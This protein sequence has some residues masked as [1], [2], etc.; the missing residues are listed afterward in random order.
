MERWRL[1]VSNA[2]TLALA[3]VVTVALAG[4]AITAFINQAQNFSNP[5]REEAARQIEKMAEEVSIVYWI[6]GSLM[7]KNEGE[8][9][10]TI[11]KAFTTNGVYDLNMVLNPGEKK[12]VNIPQSD[13]L[14][15]QTS[16]GGLIKL[17]LPQQSG[18]GSSP[19]GLKIIEGQATMV[20]TNVQIKIKVKNTSNDVIYSI[21]V[22][23][24]GEYGKT[25]IAPKNWPL[26]P[27]EEVQDT[28]SLPIS[29]YGSQ[30]Y[31]RVHGF[32]TQGGW[33]V[34]DAIWLTLS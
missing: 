33:E 4:V 1:G 26:N 12:I 7:L 32:L 19:G 6:A 29:E 34:S 20:G 17:K 28:T 11:S 2:V 24:V 10:V 30:Y 16:R 15:L 22:S 3:L 18:G 25:Y 5:V 13:L 23:I 9:P 14:V 8:V 21:S 31:V 27:G